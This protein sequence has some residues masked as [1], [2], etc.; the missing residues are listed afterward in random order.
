MVA[1]ISASGKALVTV[2]ANIFTSNDAATGFMSF[3]VTNSTYGPVDSRA[4]TVK[5]LLQ[6]Q[7]SATFLLTGLTQ[8]DHTFAARYKDDQTNRTAT[9]SNRGIIVI[10]MA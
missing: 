4:V 6:V 1:T 9:F 5:G 3:D 10:P 2:T 7:A 8:G